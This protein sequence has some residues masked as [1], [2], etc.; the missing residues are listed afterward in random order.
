MFHFSLRDLF[1]LT[2]VVALALGW[3][4]DRHPPRNWA[5][6][7]HTWFK[8]RDQP[9]RSRNRDTSWSEPRR[10]AAVLSNELFDNNA[11]HLANRLY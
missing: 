5:Y 8:K 10:E 11:R 1:W 4:V 7:L 9:R 6:P 2:I 3:F